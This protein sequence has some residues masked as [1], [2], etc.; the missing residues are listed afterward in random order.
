MS[1]SE[2]WV[3][4]S[5]VEFSDGGEPSAMLLHRG[6]REDCEF[7]ADRLPAVAYNGTRPVAGARVV[8]CPAAALESRP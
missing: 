1:E 2:M 8:T 7:V 3:C 6:S 4:V 5:V